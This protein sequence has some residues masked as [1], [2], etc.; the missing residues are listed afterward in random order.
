MSGYMSDLVKR[1][2]DLGAEHRAAGVL[3]FGTPSEVVWDGGSARLLD[4]L[5]VTGQTTEAN[6]D[7]RHAVCVAY[8]AGRGA[9]LSCYELGSAH[10]ACGA[11]PG[12]ECCP[13]GDA[14]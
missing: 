11:C 3:P 5:G 6:Q 8:A 2:R 7:S 10:C 13:E 14:S 12:Q 1:A 4:A 9:C